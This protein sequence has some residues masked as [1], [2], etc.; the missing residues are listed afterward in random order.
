MK[1]KILIIM[2]NLCGGGAEKVLVDI[3]QNFDYSQYQVDLALNLNEGVYLPDIP[4]NVKTIALFNKL[5]FYIGFGLLKFLNIHFVNKLIVKRKITDQYDA[6]ISFMEGFPLVVHSYLTEQTHNN[7][8][9]IHINL[10]AFHHSAQLSI[11]GNKMEERC[12]RKMNQLVFVSNDSA[13]EFDN[14]FQ[15]DVPKVV[16]YNPIPRTA[17]IDQAEQPVPIQKNKLVV[18]NVAR[19]AEQKRLDRLMRVA[20]RFKDSNYDIEFWLIGEGKLKDSLL[21]Q[22]KQLGLENYVKFLGFKKPAYPY[23]KQFDIFLLT[24]LTEGFPL[25]VCE[26]VCLGLPICATKTTGSIEILDSGEYG[27]LTEHDDDA[28]FDALKKLVDDKELRDFYH[29]KSLERSNMFD[30]QKTM[31][32]IYALL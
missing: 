8:S 22:Q 1:K 21:E 9:W 16:I 25:V 13:K 23:M 26:A 14:L 31:S 24:S 19:F 2:H 15:L 30:I 7:I 4:K 3:L 32:E 28:I 5:T 18:G 17:I 29:Q 27:V 20:K 6:I 12:Y 11:Y 10:F